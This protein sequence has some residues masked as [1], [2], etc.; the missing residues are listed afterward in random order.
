MAHDEI[1]RRW[2]VT[3][4]KDGVST[5]KSLASKITEIEQ[6]YF[7]VRNPNDSFRV[8]IKNGTEAEATTKSGSGIKRR[9]TPPEDRKIN[10][11]LGREIM[12]MAYHQL[13]KTRHE[14][15]G[16]EIDVCHEP[17][18]GVIIAEK[19][20]NSIDEE[21][22]LPDCIEEAKEVTDYLTSLHLARLATDLRGTGISAIPFVSEDLLRSIPCIALIGGTGAGKTGVS[23]ILRAEF[24]EIHF[25]PEVATIV[26]DRLGIKPSRNPI[27]NRRFQRAIYETTR[28]FRITSTEYA[29]T[30]NKKG[31]VFD[32]P[33][34][35]G[36]EY[37]D[38]GIKEF[39][40]ILGTSIVAEFRKVDIAILLEVPSKEIY[41]QHKK[42]NSA[43][44]ESYEEAIEREIRA[45]EIWQNHHNLHIISNEGGW[46]EK[47]ERV[48]EL[49]KSIVKNK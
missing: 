30:H 37:F 25:V 16:F 17:L 43:R 20:M 10:L 11:G 38:G 31:L 46:D 29:V 4:I 23:K 9:E 49:I 24:P 18:E 27:L 44:S 15:D 35:G 33:E 41:E 21:V 12:T 40:E 26:I 39:E 3:R 14:I 1:E 45:K 5:L 47:V 7:E 42:N 32:R 48:R 36:A 22:R 34:A 19:E 13:S 28:I 2:L 6:G 8:R